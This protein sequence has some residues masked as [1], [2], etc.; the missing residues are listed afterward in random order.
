[1]ECEILKLVT[2]PWPRPLK[3]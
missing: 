1:M 2:W 3:G